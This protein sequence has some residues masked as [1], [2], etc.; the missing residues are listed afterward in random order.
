MD[1]R[2]ANHVSPSLQS[3]SPSTIAVKPVLFAIADS[4]GSTNSGARMRIEGIGVLVS[5]VL[6]RVFRP[7]LPRAISAYDVGEF[8]PKGNEITHTILLYINYATF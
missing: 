2:S 7:P 3:H 5:G 1:A 4:E 6:A 8:P